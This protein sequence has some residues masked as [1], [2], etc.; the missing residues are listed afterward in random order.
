MGRVEEQEEAGEA[1]L[2]PKHSKEYCKLVASKF[3]LR[4]SNGMMMTKPLEWDATTT[5]LPFFKR[6]SKGARFFVMVISLSAN[7]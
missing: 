7:S 5:C 1:I 3:L 6:L 4:L 2:Q